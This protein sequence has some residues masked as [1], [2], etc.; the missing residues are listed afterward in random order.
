MPK[1]EFTYLGCI[2]TKNGYYKVHERRGDMFTLVS[3]E[4]KKYFMMLAKHD[5]N[6]SLHDRFRIIPESDALG[7][8][9]HWY[10]LKVGI[11]QARRFIALLSGIELNPDMHLEYILN[12]SKGLHGY[13]LLWNQ[14]LSDRPQ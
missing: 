9:K 10:S 14:M 7:N 8:E 5:K 4:G 2:E 3:Y 6:K 1:H 11:N 12:Y 13:A